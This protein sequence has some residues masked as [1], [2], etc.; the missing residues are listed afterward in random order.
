MRCELP[1]KVALRDKVRD[2]ITYSRDGWKK[3]DWEVSLSIETEP[4]EA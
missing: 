4:I 2:E 1:E 3:M